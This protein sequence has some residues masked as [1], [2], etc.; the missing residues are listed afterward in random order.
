MF[1]FFKKP[2]PEAKAHRFQSLMD[3]LE[4]HPGVTDF[5]YDDDQVTFAYKNNQVVLSVKEWRYPDVGIYVKS[6]T[7]GILS[8]QSICRSL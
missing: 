4:Q 2:E 8:I 6:K 3:S 7:G 1:N 5:I